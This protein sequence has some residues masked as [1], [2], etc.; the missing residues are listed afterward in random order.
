MTTQTMD[1][2]KEEAKA[3]KIKGYHLMGEER[4]VEEV[5]K[6]KAVE[7]VRKKAPRIKVETATGNHRQQK[8]DMLN[9]AN[10]EYEHQYRLV[11]TDPRVIEAKG[12][13]VVE[14]ESLGDEIVV[15]TMKDSFVEWQNARNAAEAEKMERGIDS[16]GT[17]IMRQ[18]ASPKDHVKEKT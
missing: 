8:L 4:L 7:P 9:A 2:L 17:K 16:T 6:A 15:R 3:L 14:G 18:T 13:E 12:F 10:P 11:G 5:Q 1:T